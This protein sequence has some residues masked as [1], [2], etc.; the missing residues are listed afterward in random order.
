MRIKV[1]ASFELTSQDL[2]GLSDDLSGIERE[3]KM[4]ECI[5]NFLNWEYVDND[6]VWDYEIVNN[7]N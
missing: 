2:F 7:E 5:I 1:T 6:L 3:M 4:R